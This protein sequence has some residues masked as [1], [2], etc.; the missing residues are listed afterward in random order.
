MK[1]VFMGTPDFAVP[2]LEYLKK[3][4][5]D[6]KLV[7]TQ[8]DKPKGRGRKLTPP[9]VKV[10]ALELGLE[11]FQP[12]N[13]NSEESILKLKEISPDIVVVVAYG[14]ILKENILN[15]PK[16]GCINV[17]ASLLPFYRGAA[18]INWAIINGEKKTGI[19]TMY[20][21]KGLDTGDILLKEEIEID[22]N[23][24][25]QELHDKLK[26]IGAELLINTLED[27]DKGNI[28][29]IKQDDSVATYAPMLD[30]DTGKIDFNKT[31]VEIKN[32]VRGT[33]PWPGAF[34]EYKGERIKVF[35]VDILNEFKNGKI[36]EVLKADKD[37]IFVKAKDCCI[38]IKEIQ[39]PGKKRM[40]V[41]EFLKGNK[42]ET[43]IILV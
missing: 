7:I 23:M 2:T 33:N 17:H 13:V 5:Y 42:F 18:P 8:P 34:F 27:I 26:W 14:Q 37:G 20:M 11:V 25:A 16:Y 39:F 36:G 3:E 41:E 43:G 30:R 19:T 32:L 22:E 29:R 24:T 1:V 9:P 21:D 28:R 38:V 4:N 35:K 31:G 12:N 6:I 15:I 40:S 10:K